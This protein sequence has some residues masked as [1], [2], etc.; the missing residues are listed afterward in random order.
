MWQAMDSVTRLVQPDGVLFLS[1]YNDQGRL[2]KFWKRVKLFYNRGWLA[3]T[4]TLTL[5]VPV[6]IS[7]TLVMDLLRFKNPLDRY[8]KLDRGMS[9]GHDWVDWLGGY[10]FEVAKPADVIDFYQARGF[11][12]AE[13]RTV[14]N[15]SGC[16]EYVFRNSG[17]KAN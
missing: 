2:S 5:F 13:C 12:L 17:G 14:Q 10:P 6:F 4:I 15:R 7:G 9:I 1:L 11:K 8:R 3:R 16:N